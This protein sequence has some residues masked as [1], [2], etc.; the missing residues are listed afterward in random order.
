MKTQLYVLISGF[1]EKEQMKSD[2]NKNFEIP[3]R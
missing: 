3:E 2:K 1:R